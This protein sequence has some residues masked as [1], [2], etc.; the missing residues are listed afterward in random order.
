MFRSEMSKRGEKV[1]PRYV[2]KNECE[3]S[4][5][6]RIACSGNTFLYFTQSIIVFRIPCTTCLEKSVSIM[7]ACDCVSRYGAC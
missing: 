6:I 5:Q 4:A 3:R 7:E 2:G 1:P